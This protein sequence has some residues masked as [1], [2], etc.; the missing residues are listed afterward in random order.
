MARSAS[1]VMLQQGPA[2]RSHDLA[3]LAVF[4]SLELS[5]SS[6]LMLGSAG[7]TEQCGE[8]EAG[9]SLNGPNAGRLTAACSVPNACV[10]NH[11]L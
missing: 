10:L 3:E 5:E 2:V 6:G 11:D 1:D 8:A 7:A 9:L 4:G